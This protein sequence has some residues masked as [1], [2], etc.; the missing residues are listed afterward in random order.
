MK[1]W[2]TPDLK[3]EIKN[4]FEPRYKRSLSDQEIIDIAENLSSVV[5]E[6]SKFNWIQKYGK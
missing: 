5:E 1:N 3:T 4:V 2:I 6:I